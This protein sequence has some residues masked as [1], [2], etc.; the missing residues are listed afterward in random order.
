MATKDFNRLGKW[1]PEQFKKAGTPLYKVANRSKVSRA[2]LYY[3][4]N[5]VTRP[6]SDSLLKVVRVL[7]DLS[8]QET[9]KLFAEAL[10]QYT[11]RAE[12]RKPGKEW[13]ANLSSL[14]VKSRRT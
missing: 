2:S 5:D 11:Q 8:G 4:M 12:G 14:S 3:W 1:L 10:A 6:D 9:D 13:G 7:A